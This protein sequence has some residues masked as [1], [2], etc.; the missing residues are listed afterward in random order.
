MSEWLVITK[1][2][3]NCYNWN[4]Q[5]GVCNVDVEVGVELEEQCSV[6]GND[7]GIVRTATHEPDTTAVVDVSDRCD[8]ERVVVLARLERRLSLLSFVAART[9][10][11]H[12]VA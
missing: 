10:L 9:V 1:D 7:V 5:R 3:A 12:H 6:V 4:S 11:V 8:G 2:R